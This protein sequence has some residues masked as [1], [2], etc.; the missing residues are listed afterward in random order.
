MRTFAY[1]ETAIDAD[2]IVFG[3]GLAIPVNGDPREFLF[4]IPVPELPGL[5]L[6]G[7]ERDHRRHPAH[8]GDL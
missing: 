7:G 3:P 4:P 8:L 1:N 5:L 2:D 6:P